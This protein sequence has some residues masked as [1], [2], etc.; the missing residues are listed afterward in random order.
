MRRHPVSQRLSE[1]RRAGLAE[2]A[3][4]PPD[5]VVVEALRDW[6]CAGCGG[7]GGH[8]IMDVVGPLCLTCAD[9]D[10]LIYLPRGDAALTRLA[11][12]ASRLSAVVVRFSRARRRYERQGVLVEEAALEEAER[13]CLADEEA[14][15]RRRERDEG[16]RQ[17]ADADL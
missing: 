3:S 2:R 6:T 1:R 16:R 5:L 13:Q 4:R 12:A 17:A 8:L 7:T 11:K 14:R 15:A 10:H 9:L